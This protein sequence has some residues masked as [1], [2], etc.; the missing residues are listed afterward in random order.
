MASNLDIIK[1]IIKNTP[2]KQGRKFLS[3]GDIIQAWE[4]LNIGGVL[5]IDDAMWKPEG[6]K[7]T[8]DIPHDAVQ[9]FPYPD[10]A[11]LSIYCCCST[12]CIWSGI[13]SKRSSNCSNQHRSRFSYRFVCS[14]RNRTRIPGK[15]QV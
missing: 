11:I 15:L 1:D 6:C 5:G 13:P 3:V 9:K 8:L 12:S 2:V 7:S 14:F 10:I 4:L